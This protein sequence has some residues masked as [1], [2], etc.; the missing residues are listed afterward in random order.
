MKEA[1]TKF[2]AIQNLLERYNKR[3]AAGGDYY[4]GDNSFVGVPSIKVPI[5]KS[6][7][8][9]CVILVYQNKQNNNNL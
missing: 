5:Q 3:I 6:L 9:Y 2:W 1:G 8:I 7:E 4:E